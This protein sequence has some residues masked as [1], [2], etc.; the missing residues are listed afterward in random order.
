MDTQR[1]I[2]F[3]I[4]S[5]SALLLWE[6]WQK[7]HAPPAPP[8]AT[9]PAKSTAPADLP[10][11]PAATVAPSA[12]P[13]APAT[14]AADKEPAAAGRTITITTDLYRAE[15]DTTGGAITQVALLKHRDPGDA[16]KPY[17]ALLKTPERTLVAQSGLLGEGIGPRIRRNPARAS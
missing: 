8:V 14:A 1:L 6:A 17:L 4:F 12:V 11:A 9:A 15:I 2:L 3:V 16:A 10:P 5:F 13:G 7:Q